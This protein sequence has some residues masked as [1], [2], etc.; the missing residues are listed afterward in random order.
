MDQNNGGILGKINTPTRSVASGVWSLDSQFESQSSSIWPLAFPQ[1]TIANSLRLDDSSN[2]HLSKSISGTSTTKLTISFWTKRT[3]GAGAD[4]YLVF[5]SENN[6][7]NYLSISF[8]NPKID[9]QI[10]GT[11]N[12]R[13]TNSV[14]RDE[15]A[16]YHVVITFDTT[17]STDSNRVKIYINGVQETSFFTASYPSQNFETEVNDNTEIAQVSGGGTPSLFNMGAQGTEPVT[18]ELPNTP[19]PIVPNNNMNPVNPATGL[20]TTETALLS[21]GEQAIRQRQKGMA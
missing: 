16:W 14:Y 1:T 11:A 8:G 2:R 9:V 3:D 5:N 21:P 13:I 17:Q 12:R 6:S 15:S 20:T 19:T 4:D 7:S 18:P 10:G